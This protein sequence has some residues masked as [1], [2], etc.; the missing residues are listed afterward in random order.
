MSMQKSLAPCLPFHEEGMSQKQWPNY[1]KCHFRHKVVVA[2]SEEHGFVGKRF[3]R[4]R[5]ISRKRGHTGAHSFAQVSKMFRMRRSRKCWC[6]AE[7]T[8]DSLVSTINFGGRG[9][10]MEWTTAEEAHCQVLLFSGGRGD[11]LVRLWC[12]AFQ[13]STMVWLL[14]KVGQCPVHKE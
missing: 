6:S 13:Q 5:T 1:A 7:S 11:C 3:M 4:R 12:L 8:A 10:D 2:E 9:I 14:H